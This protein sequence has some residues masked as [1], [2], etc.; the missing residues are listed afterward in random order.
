MGDMASMSVEGSCCTSAYIREP[1]ERAAFPA[2]T[3][4][5]VAHAAQLGCSPRRLSEDDNAARKRNGSTVAYG[6][7]VSLIREQGL[8]RETCQR[9]S[10]PHRSGLGTSRTIGTGLRV[11]WVGSPRPGAESAR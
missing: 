8:K 5:G 10:S 1:A 4:E 6:A 3:R 11:R 2:R 7:S 9:A